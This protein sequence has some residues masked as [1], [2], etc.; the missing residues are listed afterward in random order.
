MD[1]RLTVGIE[2]AAELLGV[3]RDMVFRL[4]AAGE[5]PS[6]KLRARRLI[7]VEGL[8][9]FVAKRAAEAVPA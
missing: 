6:F 4:I 3:K 1:E 5:I 7:P 9:A 2:E 8:R